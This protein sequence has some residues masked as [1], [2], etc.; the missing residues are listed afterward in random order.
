MITTKQKILDVAERLIGQH[1]FAATSLRQI[2]GEAGVNLAAVHYH[3]GSKEELLDDLISRKASWVNTERLARLDRLEQEAESRPIPVEKV[4]TAFFEPV[5]ETAD[6]NPQF[7]RLMGRL[8]AEGMMPAVVAKHFQP[9][10]VRF[11]KALERAVP[12]LP[13]GEL[14]WR[15]QFMIGAMTQVLCGKDPMAAAVGI[16]H[17]PVVFATAIRQLIVF[18][19][20]GFRAPATP[21]PAAAAKTPAAEVGQ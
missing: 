13:A 12:D 2:I 15:L 11:I 6:Q 18:L 8:Y 19:S 3:F 16:N 4:L 17:G 10:V 1:G 7:V 5:I 21:L 20:A 14:Y 9:T